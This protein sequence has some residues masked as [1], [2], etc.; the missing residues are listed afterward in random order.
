[1]ILFLLV[2]VKNNVFAHETDEK[3][4]KVGYYENENFQE[5]AS[6]GAVKSGYAYEYFQEIATYNGWRYEY[7]YGS[8]SEMYDAFIKGDIDLLA[9][10]GY[11][12]DRLEIMNYPN[13][14]MGFESYYLFVRAN[15]DEITVDPKNLNGKWYESTGINRRIY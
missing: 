14:P 1:M 2:A 11:A 9:G 10:P 5:G 15:N 8:W 6:K 3:I 13:Y 7:V 4:V 12:E